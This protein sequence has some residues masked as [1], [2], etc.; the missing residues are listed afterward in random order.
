MS[1]ISVVSWREQATI[2]DV[3]FIL[4]Y[5]ANT[6]SWIFIVQSHWNNSPWVDMSLHFYTLSLLRA[7]QY[8][9][10]LLNVACIAENSKQQI[11]IVQSLF[12]LIRLGRGPSIYPPKACTVTITTLVCFNKYAYE[13]AN[14]FWNNNFIFSSVSLLIMHIKS[15]INF[16]TVGSVQKSSR[17]S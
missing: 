8:L 5:L 9:R 1:D 15:K 4:L 10:F 11:L 3:R 12:V 6:L 16:H 17:K 13:I 7:N 2:D 14:L